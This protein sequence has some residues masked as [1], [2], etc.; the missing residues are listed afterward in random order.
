MSPGWPAELQHGRVGLRP[1]RVRDAGEWRRLH[2]ANR[3]WLT[4]WEATLPEASGPGFLSVRSMIRTLRRRA[5]QGHSMPFVVTWDGQ[6]VGQMTVSGITMGSARWASVGYWVAQSHAG[7]GITPTALALVCDHLLGTVGLH[8]VEI[9]IRPENEA[10][11]R[12]VQKLGFDRIGLAERYLHI[13]GRW[14]DHWLFQ[15]V[16]EDVPGGMLA[17][18]QPGAGH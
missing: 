5:R 12:V 18:L 15:V 10:S 3:E 7:R 13:A 2:D 14:C 9:A 17:R 4:L 1:L 11:L 16:A 6:M 8:R